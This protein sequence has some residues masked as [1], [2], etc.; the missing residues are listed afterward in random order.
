MSTSDEERD[1]IFCKIARGEIPAKIVARENGVLAFRDLN[2]KAP[3]HLLVIPERH[4]RD[5]GEFAA[6]AS[7]QELGALLALASR[8]GR[9]EGPGGYRV[10][11]NE[12]SDGGQ[13]VH[14]LHLHVLAG[15]RMTWPP[16]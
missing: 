14:H 4:A 2:P 16:G 6:N 7:S 11:I 12:G 8:L 1:C 9:A 15:R 13:T 10:V 5:L 3:T